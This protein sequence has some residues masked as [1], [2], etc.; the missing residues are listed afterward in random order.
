[1][2]TTATEITS[3][4][5]PLALV[6][7]A[8]PDALPGIS[9]LL[10][11]R[12]F[13]FDFLDSHE[14][15]YVAVRRRRPALVVLCSSHDDDRACQLLAM[16]QLDPL[17]K[18]VPVVTCEGGEAYAIISTPWTRTSGIPSGLNCSAPCRA[19]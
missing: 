6:V 12:H 2:T 19:R 16:L 13:R 17:T 5:V 11:D 15:P 4:P 18:H 8:G 3:L 10:G 7:G 1:M 14:G 9:A